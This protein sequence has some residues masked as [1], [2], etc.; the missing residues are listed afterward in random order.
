MKLQ[1]AHRVFPRGESRWVFYCARGTTAKMV[2]GRRRRERAY[3][4]ADLRLQNGSL[5]TSTNALHCAHHVRARSRRAREQPRKKN[6]LSGLNVSPDLPILGRNVFTGAHGGSRCWSRTQHDARIGVDITRIDDDV[7]DCLRRRGHT[8]ETIA[9]MAPEAAFAEYCNWR[10][11]LGL[12]PGLVRA[13]DGLR[14]AAVPKEDARQEKERHDWHQRVLAAQPFLNAIL[15]DNP[16]PDSIA[17]F[18]VNVV[19][20]F[21]SALE[22]AGVPVTGEQILACIDSQGSSI[23]TA[24]CSGATRERLS[25]IGSRPKD[26]YQKMMVEARVR[27]SEMG[28]N[29]SACAAD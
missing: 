26:W 17:I 16:N 11:L 8:D 13:L 23:D 19:V 28:C 6:S 10:G 7:L 4:S 18:A 25:E 27:I 14:A 20:A 12:G 22:E 29:Q 3:A 9:A 21:A 2:L 1:P 15:A 5:A 24:A